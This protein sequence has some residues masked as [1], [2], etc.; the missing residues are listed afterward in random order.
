MPGVKEALKALYSD[1]TLAVATNAADSGAA[2][3]F[4]ALERAGLSRYFSAIFT[5]REL[6]AV[7]PHLAYFRAALAAL[8]C[9]P[10]EAVMVATAT[11]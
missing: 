10:A 7:K 6:G 3:V 2:L 11:R 1:Y 9:S 4:S 8:G 5:A